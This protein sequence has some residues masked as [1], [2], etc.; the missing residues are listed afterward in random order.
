MKKSKLLVLVLVVVLFGSF[1]ISAVNGATNIVEKDSSQDEKEKKNDKIQQLEQQQDILLSDEGE[2]IDPA[3]MEEIRKTFGLDPGVSIKVVASS[4]SLKKDS[5]KQHPTTKGTS[6][7][8]ATT[9]APASTKI[10]TGSSTISPT[11]IE[12]LKINKFISDNSNNLIF[13]SLNELDLVQNSIPDSE[14]PGREEFIEGQRLRGLI[15]VQQQQQEDKIN[16]NNNENSNNNNKKDNLPFYPLQNNNFFLRYSGDLGTDRDSFEDISDINSDMIDPIKALHKMELAASLGN[17]R[18][19]YVLGIMHEMGENGVVVD[20]K[21]AEYWYL[22]AAEHGNSD[23]QKA[24]GFIYA[25]G[26]LGYIDEAKAILY[27]TFAAKS[28][29]IIA[30]LSLAYRYANGYGTEKSCVKSARLYEAVAKQYVND[31]ESRGFGYNIQYEHL[32][33]FA[34]SS[35][36]TDEDDVVEFLKYSASIG[37]PSSLVTMANLYLQGGLVKQDFRLAFGYY[38]DAASLNFPAGVAG[39]GFMY[40]KGYGVRQDNKTAVHYFKKAQ[41]LGHYGAQANLAEMLMYG[42]GTNKDTS[43]A[44]KLLAES[45][46]KG[47]PEA[48]VQ[49]GKLYMNGVGV[50]KDINKALGYFSQATKYSNPVAIYQIGK[51]ILENHES[52]CENAVEYFKRVSEKGAWAMAITDAHKYFDEDEEQTALLFFEKAAEMGIEAAQYNAGYMYDKK[53]G[54]YSID[55]IEIEHTK[56]DNN[57]NEDEQNNNNNEQQQSDDDEPITTTTTTPIGYT[58]EFIYQQAFRNY[59][60]SSKQNNADAH[61]KIGDFYYYGKG[62]EKSIDKAADFYQLSAS[63]LNSQALFNLGY[64]HQYGEGKPQDLFLAKRY[65]DMAL[66][67]ESQ[68]YFPIYISLVSLLFHFIYLYVNSFFNPSIQFSSSS[69]NSQHLDYVGRNAAKRDQAAQS[70][71]TSGG[72]LSGIELDELEDM[73]EFSEHT[74][75]AYLMIIIAIIIGYIVVRRQRVILREQRQRHQVLNQVNQFNFNQQQQPQPQPQPQNID[76]IQQPD[77]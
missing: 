42:Y 66:Q 31:Y 68:A 13:K 34:S 59:Y 36:N 4:D 70:S 50:E 6:P 2:E 18:A 38:R 64:M 74:I 57:D 41:G 44:I 75:E 73:D 46:E 22:K 37:D 39:L 52:D 32:S 9:T 20:F 48:F 65:Y 24:L 16:N 23:A 49:L 71:S 47:T 10:K 14:L 43:Q 40:N 26:K 72:G 27:Y 53:L 21:K 5:K 58:T 8:T 60:H 33:D 76:Q 17:H 28:G 12:Q 61:L 56:I 62:V 55:D 1:L 63:L 69:E 15:L 45:A 25:T 11:I 35:Q 7:T 19:M 29:N 3:M 54:V 67:I 51:Y 30:Q 77:Q